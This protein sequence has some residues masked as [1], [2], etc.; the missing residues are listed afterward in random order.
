MR[1][2]HNPEAFSVIAE[3]QLIKAK[4]RE[5]SISFW[6]ALAQQA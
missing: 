2:H 1:Y 5:D 4:E 3:V 6:A